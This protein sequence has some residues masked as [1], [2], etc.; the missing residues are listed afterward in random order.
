M[1]SYVTL[2]GIVLSLVVGFT[3]L[4]IGI[5]NSRKTIFINSI[6]TSRLKYIEDLRKNI[7]EFCGLAYAYHSSTK[8][9]TEPVKEDSIKI[10]K[11]SCSIKLYL[12]PEC[13]KFD[14]QIIHLL[15]EIS[16]PNI[17]EPFAK[18]DKLITISQ[19]LLMLEW[20]GV[21]KESKKGITSNRDIS[22]LRNKYE[23][24]FNNALNSNK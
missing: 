1:E 18:I 4:W 10:F 12:D 15:D 23:Q 14:M 20:Q 8:K 9:E 17:K 5:K 13:D 21:K 6:T 7:A 2:I 19:Y 3:S 16:K 22:V 24:L 11:L